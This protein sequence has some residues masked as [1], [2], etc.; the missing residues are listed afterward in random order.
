MLT[1]LPLLTIKISHQC[2][3]FLSTTQER[4]H[5]RTQV[6]QM[7]SSSTYDVHFPIAICP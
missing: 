3:L 5:N 4:N 1:F 6:N 7:A 2:N